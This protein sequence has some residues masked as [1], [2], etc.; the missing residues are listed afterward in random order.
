MDPVNLKEARRRLGDLV[1]AAE[2]G[3]SVTITRRG[4]EVARLVPIE[5]KRAKR[6]PDLAA[7]RASI[8]VRGRP[9]SEV[10]IEARQ[11]AR[12]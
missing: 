12:Y 6:P 10:V 9:L 2:S 1:R 8:E 4:R 5:P 11:E 7:F 3:E